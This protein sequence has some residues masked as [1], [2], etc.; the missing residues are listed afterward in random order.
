MT[1]CDVCSSINTR[2][3]RFGMMD[4]LALNQIMVEVRCDLCEGCAEKAKDKL[5]N[6]MENLIEDSPLSK[7]PA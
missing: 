2:P 4:Q 7:P 3:F 1:I 6:L 5:R